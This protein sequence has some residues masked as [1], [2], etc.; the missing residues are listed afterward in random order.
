MRNIYAS[1]LLRDK[2]KFASSQKRGNNLLSCRVGNL[3]L[4]SKSGSVGC[5]SISRVEA[6]LTAGV[7]I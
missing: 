4:L 7:T 3:R 6:I 2:K 5:L 1:G